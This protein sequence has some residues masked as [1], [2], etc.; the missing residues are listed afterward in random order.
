MNDI[1]TAVLTILVI[2]LLY[3]GY[4]FLKLKVNHNNDTGS[5]SKEDLTTIRNAFNRGIT[6]WRG[7]DEDNH[8]HNNSVR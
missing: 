3:L 1:T 8:N 2:G 5:I 7:S 6:I 4:Y